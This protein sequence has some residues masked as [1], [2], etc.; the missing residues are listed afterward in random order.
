MS[1]GLSFGIT[2]ILSGLGKITD[3]MIKTKAE[4][5]ELNDE[6]VSLAQS[7]NGADGTR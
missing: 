5:R 6:F 7:N 2:A 3:A 4:T 1:M